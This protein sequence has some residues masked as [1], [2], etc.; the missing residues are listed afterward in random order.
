MGNCYACK[1]KGW[2]VHPTFRCRVPCPECRPK[3]YT[4]AIK[5]L[6]KEA[7]RAIKIVNKVADKCGV[8]AAE[9]SAALKRSVKSS[10][11]TTE[12]QAD[13]KELIEKSPND[14]PEKDKSEEEEK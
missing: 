11:S 12:A 9:A 6:K 7:L 10:L 2:G 3:D 13:L 4:K 14:I 5:R 1:G 8:T